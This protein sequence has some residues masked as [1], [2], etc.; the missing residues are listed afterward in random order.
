[1]NASPGPP[2]AL[3][4]RG[5]TV[6]YGDRPGGAAPPGTRPAVRELSFQVRPGEI[7]GLLGSNGAGKTT[8]MKCVAGLLRPQVGAIRVL[9]VDPVADPVE[10]KRRIGYVP[11]SPLLFDALT[12]REFLEFVASVRGL[13]T[14]V[15][16]RRTQSFAKAFQIEAELNQPIALLSMGTR[17][18]VLFA[19]A[20]L[21]RPP[22]L[23][24]DEPLHSLDPRG[25]RIARELLRHHASE[26][27]GGVLLSTHTMEIAERLCDRVGILDQGRLVGEGTIAEL[28]GSGS[29]TLEEAFLKLTREEEGVRAALDSLQ[30]G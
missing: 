9:G 5:L 14:D 21:H 8:T 24:L 4:V 19:A 18:K 7:Y 20:L 10:A 29:A 15:A 28:R 13:G 6:W 12:P 2:A 22:L 25:V 27:P 1:M 16:T 11:E 23:V 26:G 17:Q 30:S 3:D